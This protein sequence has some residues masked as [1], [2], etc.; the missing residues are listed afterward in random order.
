MGQGRTPELGLGFLQCCPVLRFVSTQF[1]TAA[2]CAAAY[3]NHF[4]TA[5]LIQ[6]ITAGRWLR[7][8]GVTVF[9]RIEAPG[10]Y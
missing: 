4:V 2:T 10:L 3:V 7:T 6:L 5:G 9:P 1:T 8:E